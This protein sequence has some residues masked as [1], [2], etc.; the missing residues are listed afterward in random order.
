ML[1]RLR[2]SHPILYCIL[3]I[4]LFWAVMSQGGQL[5]ILLL[6]WAG[7][8]VAAPFVQENFLLQAAGDLLGLAAALVLLWRTDQLWAFTKR[9]CGFWDGLLVGMTPF[10]MVCLGLAVNVGAPILPEDAVLKAPWRIAVFFVTM[11][12]I[13]LTE[14]SMFRGVVGQTLLLHFGPSRT[15]VWKACLL[16]G[17]LFGALHLTNLVSSAPLGV[18]IQCCMAGGLGV[19]YGAIYFRTGNLWVVIA[20]HALQDTAALVNTGLYDGVASTSEVVSSY[21]P[22]MLVGLLF[23]LVPALFLLRRSRLPLVAAYWGLE[24]ARD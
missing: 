13:G 6:T 21:D 1:K 15:G 20:L 17:A 7:P 4:A 3:A 23:Y 22:S 9:G 12:L 14:E 5:L 8:A 18:L 19:L 11:F 24:D 2:A 10:V 16:S